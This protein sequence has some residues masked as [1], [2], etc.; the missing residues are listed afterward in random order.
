MSHDSDIDYESIANWRERRRKKTY[1]KY[2]LKRQLKQSRPMEFTDSDS[3]ELV[4]QSECPKLHRSCNLRMSQSIIVNNETNEISAKKRQLE[5]Q[6]NSDE[7]I[8]NYLSD[9]CD[10]EYLSSELSSDSD[11]NLDSDNTL[12][13]DLARTVLETNMTDMQTNRIL[14]DLKKHGIGPLPSDARTLKKRHVVHPSEIKT[15]SGMEYYY[16]GYKNQIIRILSRYPD[17]ILKKTD[18]LMIKDNVDGLPLYKSSNIS[19]WP[20]LATIDNLHPSVVFPVVITVGVSKPSDLEFLSEA[21]AEIN[22]LN[23][24]GIVFNGR[25]IKVNFVAHICDTPARHM[26]KGIVSFNA[27][28]GCDY[29]TTKG[30]YDG[31]RMI[32]PSTD[33]TER[34]NEKFRDR[35]QPQHHRSISPSMFE[36]TQ[37]DMINDFPYD[38]M[39]I[40]SGVTLKLITWITSGPKRVDSSGILCRMSASNVRILNERLLAIRSCI[41]NCFVRRP[42]G[43]KDLPRFKATELRQLLLYTSKLLLS[44]LMPTDEH[45]EH[46][47]EL[48]LGCA[49]LVDSRTAVS[50]ND[51][52]NDLLK[53]FVEKIS[54]LYGNSFMVY[55]I[56]SLLHL[57]K[58]ASSHGC[59][60]SVSAYPFENKLGALKKSVRSPLHPIMSLIKSTLMEMA[61][62]KNKKIIPHKRKPYTKYPNNVYID[63]TNHKCYLAYAIVPEGVKVQLF[64]NARPLLTSPLDSSIVGCYKV[65]SAN[66]IYRTINEETLLSFR[67]GMMIELRQIKKCDSRTSVF[68]AMLHSSHETKYC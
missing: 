1:R 28:Y 23:N 48:S 16:F 66:Y 67:R 51:M 9:L 45:Y 7:E 60:D 41:P 68:M 44:D 56:H 52:A 22:D 55:N 19:V 31:K 61:L 62:N 65:N 21:V 26:V 10:Q 32:W 13:E 27:F 14:Q 47:C 64:L 35:S 30:V 54:R 38:F 15:I 59:L 43:I 3:D 42:R 33:F 11:R 46:I 25:T 53:S 39:H 50:Y 6:G 36:F 29:C 12:W 2:G 17:E 8:I 63:I 58:T 34:S 5:D 37:C 57:A 4:S 24:R 20:L 18:V 49:L 40:C